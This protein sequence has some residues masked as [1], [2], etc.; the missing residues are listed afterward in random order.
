NNFFSNNSLEFIIIFKQQLNLKKLKEAKLLT[1]L[2]PCTRRLQGG[3][4]SGGVG[5]G[6]RGR[7]E[8]PPMSSALHYE[9]LYLLNNKI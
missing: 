8:T 5:G 6:K 4:K 9:V 2:A 3:K 1:K 7:I